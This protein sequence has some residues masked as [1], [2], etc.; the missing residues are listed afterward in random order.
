MYSICG[1]TRRGGG[2]EMYFWQFLTIFGQWK[3]GG[4]RGHQRG[5]PVKSS[6]ATDDAHRFEF[7]H[8]RIHA[9][10]FLLVNSCMQTAPVPCCS[11]T[12]ESRI[13]GICASAACH[14]PAR[15][16]TTYAHRLGLEG[17]EHGPQL[18]S[19][20]P[21]A[22]SGSLGCCCCLHRIRWSAFLLGKSGTT[23]VLERS[24]L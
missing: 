21:A 17:V 23:I 24:K 16:V 2:S 6:T 14:H 22:A 11:L 10:E 18:D 13:A 4:L 3:L 9:C 20:S 5:P 19:S 12:K 7:M 8:A 15:I 1:K